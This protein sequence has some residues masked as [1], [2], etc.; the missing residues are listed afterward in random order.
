[1]IKSMKS[2]RCSICH[3][4][5]RPAGDTVTSDLIYSPKVSFDGFP[6]L[7]SANFGLQPVN[8]KKPLPTFAQ[9]VKQSIQVE[10]THKGWCDQ[11]RR[12]QLQ[13]TRKSISHLPDVLTFNA[14]SNDKNLSLARDYWGTPGWL[15]DQIGIALNNNHLNVWQGDDVKVLGSRSNDLKIYD[16]V[17]Y[18]A[19]IK[20]EDDR[21]KHMVSFING[22]HITRSSWTFH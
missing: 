16:L 15:P 1:M 4:E 22:L 12:Y 17:G 11:C 6:S 19:E 10:T 21:R 13:G 20:E 9:T 3:K 8:A 7:N 2:Q 18:V 14:S 5:T